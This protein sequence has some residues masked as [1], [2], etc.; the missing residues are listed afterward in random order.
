MD[1]S[2][3]LLIRSQQFGTQMPQGGHPPIIQL[4]QLV[5]GAS[6]LTT[7]AARLPRVPEKAMPPPRRRAA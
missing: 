4:Q 6:G 3:L 5:D 1:G 2:H 7:S